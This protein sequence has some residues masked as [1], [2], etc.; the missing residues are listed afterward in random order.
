M[1]GYPLPE[2]PPHI[3]QPGVDPK[4]I[5]AVSV[6][7]TWI[8]GLSDCIERDSYDQFPELFIDDCWW[9]DF[10][11][12]DWDFSTKHGQPNIIEYLS[13]APNRLSGLRAVHF[14]GLKPL[15]VQLP[16]M[17]WIQGGF[18]FRNQHGT[19]RGLVKLLN[20]EGK[21]GWKAWS[22][23]TQLESLDF[24]HE[25]ERQRNLNPAAQSHQGHTN[26]TN[27]S[28]ESTRDETQVLIVGAGM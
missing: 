15:L 2:I 14:G 16:G 8:T 6:F 7:Q 12:L 19:G 11:S 22:V 21:A 4:D 13:A 20:V 27:G 3:L 5:D 9:R 10:V 1:D 23:F 26:G 25:L 24:Q 18:T 28:P 17:V